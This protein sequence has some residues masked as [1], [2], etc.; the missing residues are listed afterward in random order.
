MNIQQISDGRLSSY[1]NF[2]SRKKIQKVIFHTLQN[3][4]SFSNSSEINFKHLNAEIT[5]RFTNKKEIKNLNFNYRKKNKVTDILTFL[6]Q[7]FPNLIAD[8]VICL[9]ITKQISF[10]RKIPNSDN[11]CHLLIH[12]TL[13]ATGLDHIKKKEA[14]RMEEIEI[15]TLNFFKISNPYEY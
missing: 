11:L 3:F 14:K 1:T 10:K 15:K 2:I 9:P 13:H 12:G 4:I 6:Y 7:P 8:I 5:V